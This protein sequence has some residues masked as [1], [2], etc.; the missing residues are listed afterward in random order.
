MAGAMVLAAMPFSA[1]AATSLTKE[2]NVLED[3]EYYNVS[4][5]NGSNGDYINFE[6]TGV[7]QDGVWYVTPDTDL[8]LVMSDGDGY[9]SDNLTNHGY[10][11]GW[12]YGTTTSYCISSD[13]AAT[14]TDGTYSFSVSGLLDATSQNS[15][16]AS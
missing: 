10:N 11:L 8:T 7:D 1:T 3:S 13:T 6:Y 5:N 16:T 12:H 14:M 9:S 2:T 4:L 15:L